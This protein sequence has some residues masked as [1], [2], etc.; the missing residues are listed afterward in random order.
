VRPSLRS[1]SAPGAACSRRGA[2]GTPPAHRLHH[3]E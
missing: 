2:A 3:H 1:C